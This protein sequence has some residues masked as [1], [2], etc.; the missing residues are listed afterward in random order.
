MI[1]LQTTCLTDSCAD[2][3]DCS[4]I[5]MQVLVALFLAITF[6]QS[7]LDK[8]F[9]YK[10]NLEFMKSHFAKSLLYR[11][12]GL[13]LFKITILELA[14]GAFSLAGV[15]ML[16]VNGCEFYI[17]LGAVLSALSILCLFA[18]QSMAKDYTGATALIGY[19]IVSLIGIWL[20]M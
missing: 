12:T 20:T 16:L 19:F 11:I 17:F 9:N 4:Y 15:I 5:I 2:S 6:L 1:L 13:L 18:G 3:S 8:V 14:A 7:G 10:D